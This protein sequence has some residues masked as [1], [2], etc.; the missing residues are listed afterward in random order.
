MKN[1]NLLYYILLI[2]TFAYSQSDNL[3]SYQDLG[4]IFSNVDNGSTAR[5]RAMGGS[6]NALGGDMSTLAVNPAGTAIFL[7][8]QIA[9]TLEGYSKDIEANQNSSNTSR[10]TLS[11]LGVVFA[12]KPSTPE[13]NFGLGINYNNISDFGGEWMIS[14]QNLDFEN[15]TSG[16]NG[17]FTV[18][19]AADYDKKIA[20]GANVNTYTLHMFQST[21]EIDNSNQA[22]YRELQNYGYGIS[23][24]AGIILRPVRSFR[25]GLAY[26]APVWYQLTEE[27]YENGNLN[28]YEYD[29][30]TPGTTTASAAMVI[31]KFFI[32][33]IDYTYRNYTSLKLKPEHDFQ[34]ENSFY[35][36]N[37][38]NTSELRLG[39][40]I[41]IKG[42]SLRTGAFITE[43]PYE[44]VALEDSRY[45]A[46]AGIGIRI[47]YT[48]LDF[49]YE[50]SWNTDT[51]AFP[52]NNTINVTDLNIN[53]NKF[54]FSAIFNL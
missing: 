27:F 46:S 39:S 49:A 12:M 9:G 23:F 20:F 35:K 51:Y 48:R 38:R 18:S 36:N 47:G 40:E 4:I 21:L 31:G 28:G 1:T 22:A 5:S 45:G 19:F 24:G 2:S 30:R 29:L 34:A 7:K 54:T 17:R 13:W 33:N 3:Y 10:T 41:R 25:L 32:A 53:T 15:Y 8:T 50:R 26:Q 43:S 14:D 44:T 16:Q 52:V 42:L 11:Q 6:M 37:L